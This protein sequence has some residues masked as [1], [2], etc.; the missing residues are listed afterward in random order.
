LSACGEN[1]SADQNVVITNSVPPGTD[2]EAL[3]ADESSGTSTDDLANG[4]VTPDENGA[5]NAADNQTDGY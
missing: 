3:P 4:A 2:V 1:E 5:V